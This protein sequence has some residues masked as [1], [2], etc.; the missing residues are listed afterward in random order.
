MK[1]TQL[2]MCR[3]YVSFSPVKV[4]PTDLQ[5]REP[6]RY[7]PTFLFPYW[8]PPNYPTPHYPAAFHFVRWDESL[9]YDVRWAQ[10]TTLRRLKWKGI[11]TNRIA[12]LTVYK[13][14]FLYLNFANHRTKESFVSTANKPLVGILMTIGDVTVSIAIKIKIPISGPKYGNTKKEIG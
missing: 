11:F 8:D 12:I 4:H 7:C 6:A 3:F 10:W 9:V 14:V 13:K 1:K 5:R 2:V